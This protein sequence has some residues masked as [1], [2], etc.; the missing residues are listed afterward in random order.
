MAEISTPDWVKDAIFY[1]IFPDRFARSASALSSPYLEAW[2]ATPTYHGFQGGDLD[3]ITEKL[4]Y[5]Q[6]LG[7]NALYLNP[8]FQ[9][10]TNHR[11]RTH[12]YYTVDPML[13]GN[14][15]FRRL[16]DAAHAR[17]IRVVLDGVFNH[18]GRGFFPFHHVLECEQASP[19]IEWFHIKGF[20]LRAY[21]QHSHPNYETWA[22]YRKFPKLNLNHPA[23][24]R[25]ILEVARHWLQFGIDGWRLDAFK[26]IDEDFWREFRQ[27][28]KAV[29]GDAYLLGEIWVDEKHRTASRWLAGDQ[30]DGIMN[31]GFATTCIGFF[32]GDRLD[33]HLMHKQAHRPKRTYSAEAFADRIDRMLGNY[34]APVVYAQYNLLESHDTARYLTL[35]AGDP[36]ILKLTVTFQMT[37]P[38]APAIYYGTEIGLPGGR[39]PDCRRAMPWDVT[40]WDR[41][42]LEHCRKLIT[43]RK[44]YRC[45]RRGDYARLYAHP[46]KAVFAFM[47]KLP[48]ERIV[49]I[50]NNSD[51]PY[52]V[53]IPLNGYP[54]ETEILTCLLSGKQFTVEGKRLDGPTLAGRSG[55][56]LLAHFAG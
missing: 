46:A 36:R 25:F 33:R 11:Y 17:G 50:L 41:D 29:N 10:A 19:Y 15:A 56:V 12:D 2:G 14:A 8:I 23:A 4:D 20:P 26:E 48:E 42:I 6:E 31:Y 27:A 55:A 7:I 21:D 24:R 54:A 13:G 51:D 22:G 32:I 37:Y 9:S 18:V 28:V 47:R 34:A 52:H 38:G 5:L 43:I 35:A 30:L 1:Q 16:L 3:G 39:D 45:L 53:E 49:V 40:Q 44:R